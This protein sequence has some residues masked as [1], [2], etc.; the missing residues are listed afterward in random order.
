[1]DS[2]KHNG[3]I[4]LE[5]K[6]G[7]VAMAVM[8]PTLCRDTNSFVT[9]VNSFTATTNS[10]ICNEGCGNKAPSAELLLL[11]FFSLA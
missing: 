9:V 7:A 4:L 11:L 10:W 5:K 3:R 6:I 1:M 8:L 2:G